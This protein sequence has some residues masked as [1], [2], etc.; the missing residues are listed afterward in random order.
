ML[1][2]SLYQPKAIRTYEKF[3][4]KDLKDHCIGMNIK[5]TERIEIRYRNIDIFLVETL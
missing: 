4:A 2:P 1:L 5:Q 3:F